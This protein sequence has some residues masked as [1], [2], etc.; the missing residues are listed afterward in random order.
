M[1]DLILIRK[2]CLICLAVFSVILLILAFAGFII[3]ELFKQDVVILNKES[4]NVVLLQLV[5]DDE[6]LQET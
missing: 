5:Q 3:T 6:N 1:A 2:I 4:K